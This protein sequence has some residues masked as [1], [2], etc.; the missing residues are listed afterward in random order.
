[1]LLALAGLLCGRSLR[2][3]G[4]GDKSYSLEV[5]LA[6]LVS[7]SRERF[8]PIRTYRVD[9]RPRGG[10]WYHVKHS[11]PDAEVCR[12]YEYPEMIYVCEWS[13]KQKLEFDGFV[14][15]YQTALGEGWKRTED[16]GNAKLVRLEKSGRR[17][18]GRI[19]IAA[20]GGGIRVV[21]YARETEE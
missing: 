10:S 8:R 5:L 20:S 19:E 9:M 16:S 7:A 6:L 14:K 15:R 1:M 3:Q 2:A 13:A 17:P 11:L 21:I 12:I 18:E 4:T